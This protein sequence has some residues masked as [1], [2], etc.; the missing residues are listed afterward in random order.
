MNVRHKIAKKCCWNSKCPYAISLGFEDGE[1][2]DLFRLVAVPR[3]EWL[4][5]ESSQEEY[6]HEDA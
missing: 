4:V 1:I 5:G 3:Q 6:K 2:E